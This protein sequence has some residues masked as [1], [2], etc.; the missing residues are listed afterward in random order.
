MESNAEKNLERP[1]NSAT[2]FMRNPMQ[3]EKLKNQDVGLYYRSRKMLAP[4]KTSI[5][6]KCAFSILAIVRQCSEGKAM[7]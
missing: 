6:W 5:V 1:G 4:S 2:V 3:A 7:T